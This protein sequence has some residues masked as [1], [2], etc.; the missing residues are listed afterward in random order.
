M[1]KKLLVFALTWPLGVWCF[2]MLLQSVRRGS[3]SYR[4]ITYRRDSEPFGFWLYTT[5]GALGGGLLLVC[6]TLLLIDD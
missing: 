1:T 5:M 4:G 3:I 2:Y 6:G